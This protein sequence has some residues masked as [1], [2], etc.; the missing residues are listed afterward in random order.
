MKRTW[1]DSVQAL[2]KDLSYKRNRRHDQFRNPSDRC[3]PSS[4]GNELNQNKE[5]SPQGNGHDEHEIRQVR[6]RHET[7]LGIRS[8]PLAFGEYPK[9][10]TDDNKYQAACKQGRRFPLGR[11]LN[12]F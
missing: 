2:F 5:Q 1:A 7:Q 6:M 12:R 10:S 8:G 11:Q 3:A 9:Q 4:S